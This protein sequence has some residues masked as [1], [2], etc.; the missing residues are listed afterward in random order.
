MRSELDGERSTWRAAAEAEHSRLQR[1]I[2][3]QQAALADKERQLESLRGELQQQLAVGASDLDARERE[4]RV[5][6]AQVRAQQ[7]ALR[8]AQERAAAAEGTEV[9]LRSREAELA[10]LASRLEK[11]AV[12]LAAVR[13]SLQVWARAGFWGAGGWVQGCVLGTSCC[14]AGDGIA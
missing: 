12:Q 10:A 11:D 8:R 4:V 7:E 9:G 13:S 1:V 6:E 3:D 14:G 5:A 2:Q